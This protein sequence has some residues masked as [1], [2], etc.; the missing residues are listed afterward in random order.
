VAKLSSVQKNQNRAALVKKM[1]S[2]RA[3]LKAAARDKSTSLEARFAAALKLAEVPRNSS[4]V[5]VRNRCFLTG[6][7]R[8][9]HREYGISRIVFRELANS[10]QLPG[11]IKASW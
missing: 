8:G 9:F 6:R 1:A 11:V 7:S 3:R 4:R 5:R 2:R 10:G